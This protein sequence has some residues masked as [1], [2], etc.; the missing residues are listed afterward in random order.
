M[1]FGLAFASSIAIEHDSAM[2][3]CRSAESAGFESLW[4]GE[5]VIMPSSMESKYPYTPDGK[6]PEVR[7]QHVKHLNF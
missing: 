1:K 4:G 2:E 7:M 6:V 5:H 3:V